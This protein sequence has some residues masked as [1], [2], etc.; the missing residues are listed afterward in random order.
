MDATTAAFVAL[1]I[2]VAAFALAS[3]RGVHLGIVMFVAACATGV[4]LAGMPLREVVAG[5]PVGILVLIAGVTYFFGIARLNGTVDRLIGGLL[6][7]TGDRPAA[8]TLAFA[9]LAAVAAAMGSPQAGLVTAPLGMPAARRAGVDAALMAVA[10]N[11]GI[12]AGSFAPTSLFGIITYRV[13]SQA[14][15]GITPGTL[16]TTAVVANV[17]LLAAAMALLGRPPAAAPARAIPGDG[18]RGP[19]PGDASR[20]VAPASWH[21]RATL[22]AFAVLV[23][24]IAV[25]AANGFEPDIGVATLGLG[26][27]LVLLDPAIGR[28][29]FAQI[30][31]SSAFVVGGIV[32]FVGVLQTLGV[33][34][35]LG[36]L[37]IDAGAPLVAA[38]VVCV[39]AALVSAFAST[40]GVLAAL[41]PLAVPLAVS[42]E[43]AGW[44]LIA[45]LGVSAT[46]VDASPFSNTGATLVASAAEDDRPAL[47]RALLRWCLSMVVIAPLLLLPALVL[48]SRWWP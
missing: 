29:A 1:A 4:G 31:W 43:M 16:L 36:R 44:A 27:V 39:I 14:G 24:G 21:Q 42:G 33:V 30:D 22:A 8:V 26:A 34:D 7:R 20:S 38:F 23:A 48:V 35:L 46:V 12:C 32:T 45:A 10:I 25:G 17:V 40:T 19:L 3:V 28:T 47:R 2:F 6:R 5:F 41:V 37:A 11:C 18:S 15:I 13:A 9:A